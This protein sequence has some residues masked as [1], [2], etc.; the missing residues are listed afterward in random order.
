MLKNFKDF[1]TYLSCCILK[2]WRFEVENPYRSNPS[3][4]LKR[5]S[6]TSEGAFFE[7]YI[8]QRINEIDGPSKFT[9]LIMD[10]RTYRFRS[11]D[12][13][14]ESETGYPKSSKNALCE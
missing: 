11:L 4:E 8:S 5:F 7:K 13:Q 12:A 3:L 2:D 6:D 1:K 10:L 9:V 14:S